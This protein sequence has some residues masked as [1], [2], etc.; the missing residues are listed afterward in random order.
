MQGSPPRP[1]SAR[2]TDTRD[3]GQTR[4]QH[5]AAGLGSSYTPGRSLRAGTH[6]TATA[7]AGDKGDKTAPEPPEVPWS[8]AGDSHQPRAAP[9]LVGLCRRNGTIHTQAGSGDSLAFPG[10]RCSPKHHSSAMLSAAPGGCA[11]TKGSWAEELIPPSSSQTSTKDPLQPLLLVSAPGADPKAP[12]EGAS[13]SPHTLS[14][15]HSPEEQP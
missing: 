15:C 12:G 4:G 13:C 10:S 5:G 2:G 14:D 7:G 3:M 8:L 1:Q 6:T 11:S 9:G